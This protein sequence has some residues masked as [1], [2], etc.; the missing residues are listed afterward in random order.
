[1]ANEAHYVAG[2]KRRR[3]MRE[4]G[5]GIHALFTMVMPYRRTRFRRRGRADNPAAPPGNAADARRILRWMEL[6]RPAAFV[7]ETG[8]TGRTDQAHDQDIA[9]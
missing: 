1:V 6:A 4:N 2:L 3:R 7:R 9:R 5:R 8:L